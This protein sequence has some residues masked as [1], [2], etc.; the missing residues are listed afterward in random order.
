MYK[1]LLQNS[2]HDTVSQLVMTVLYEDSSR[3]LCCSMYTVPCRRKQISQ[4][5][6]IARSY[7]NAR[8]FYDWNG[9]YLQVQVWDIY[10]GAVSGKHSTSCLC[11]QYKQAYLYCYWT[12]YPTGTYWKLTSP[13][14]GTLGPAIDVLCAGNACWLACIGVCWHEQRWSQIRRIIRIKWRHTKSYVDLLF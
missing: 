13:V 11:P 10:C 3:L 6:E 1:R 8:T 2:L 7:R 14:D 12:S 5:T 4:C 9:W